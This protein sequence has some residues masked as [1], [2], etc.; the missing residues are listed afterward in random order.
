[1]TTLFALAL[2]AADPVEIP[3]HLAETVYEGDLAE[4]KRI[5]DLAVAEATERCKAALER[6]S[7]SAAMEG[8]LNKAVAYRDRA[9]A[10]VVPE[11]TVTRSPLLG[12]YEFRW[13]MNNNVR[14]HVFEA[15]GKARYLTDSFDPERAKKPLEAQVYWFS[16]GEEIGGLILWNGE[17][18]ILSVV[19]GKPPSMLSYPKEHGHVGYGQKMK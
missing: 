1:M 8:Q 10:L 9:K 6:A 7:K 12:R 4:A 2:L 18:H 3:K 17:A 5:Y 13:P 11:A 19:K 14:Q 16:K 15:N